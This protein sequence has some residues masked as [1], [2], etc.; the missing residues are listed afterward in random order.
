MIQL[1]NSFRKTLNELKPL[2]N[3]LDEQEKKIKKIID[4]HSETS[5]Y[6]WKNPDETEFKYE[7][8]LS[9]TSRKLEEAYNES[10][11]SFTFNN[12]ELEFDITFDPE[13]YI[14]KLAKQQNEKINEENNKHNTLDR[15]FEKHDDLP[16]DIS[17][18]M[19]YSVIDEKSRKKISEIQNSSYNKLSQ[20]ISTIIQFSSNFEYLM[21]EIDES[22][23]KHNLSLD[24]NNLEN[25][26]ILREYKT[27]TL[28]LTKFSRDIT[29]PESLKDVKI[30]GEKIS[31]SINKNCKIKKKVIEGK[32]TG[33]GS[34]SSNR[35]E[36]KPSIKN[37]FNKLEKLLDELKSF[38]N[39][40]MEKIQLNKTSKGDELK[41]LFEDIFNKF[42]N[43]VNNIKQKIREYKTKPKEYTEFFEMS[44]LGRYSSTADPM[45]NLTQTEETSFIEDLLGEKS[46]KDEVENITSLDNKAESGNNE[47]LEISSS[48]FRKKILD[49]RD[50]LELEKLLDELKSFMNEIME[51][52]QLNETP[53]GDELKILFEDIFN[54]FQ[55][56]VNNIKQKIREYKT[57]PKEYTEFSEMSSLRRYSSTA[58]P[59]KNL[60]QTEETSF[61]EDL[62][63]EKSYKDEVENITSLDNKAESGN[64]EE[65]ETSSSSFRKKIL[66][67]RDQ[68]DHK[69]RSV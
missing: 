14:K 66:D 37:L 58:D 60:T 12:Q 5:I 25:N 45:K 63:G 36:P 2:Y 52:I 27:L 57:K 40:I 65:L 33:L 50:Q 18:Y 68:L 1:A 23:K 34:K 17:E 62:L 16:Y 28:N 31:K 53:K 51:K 15:V 8:S 59:M 42:Q 11:I 22:I 19:K 35:N 61:I 26:K 6:L 56:F 54:K 20:L 13:N 41:I 4:S 21:V 46:Y 67:Q 43:F 29:Y 69:E 38:M 64:N 30:W 44:S 7:T 9:K 3:H 24:E 48:S 47:E 10:K 49:Q 55:N 32:S 39:E